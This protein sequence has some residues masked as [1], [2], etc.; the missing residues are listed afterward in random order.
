MARYCATD[1]AGMR[2][3]E[4]VRRMALSARGYD[5][6]RKVARTIADLTRTESISS[7]HIAESLQFRML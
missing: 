5:R 2:L 7:D 6:V 1:R 3:L 4:A